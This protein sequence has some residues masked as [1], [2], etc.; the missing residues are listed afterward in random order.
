WPAAGR[1]STRSIVALQEVARRTRKSSR[2]RPA[3]GELH[4]QAP[5]RILGAVTTKP[6]NRWFAGGMLSRLPGLW[7]SLR[8]GSRRAVGG[9]DVERA[10]PAF[11]HF[12]VDRHLFHAAQVGQLEHGIQQDAF[13]DRAEASGARLALDGAAGDGGKRIVGEGERDVLHLEET[14]I[15]LEQR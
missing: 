7:E 8:R 5:R 14:L 6:T 1:G 11:G 10:G 9:V 2:I 15:L 4:P 12:G 3:R 13:H